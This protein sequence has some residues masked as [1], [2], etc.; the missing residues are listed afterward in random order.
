[1]IFEINRGAILVVLLVRRENLFNVSTVSTALSKLS[2]PAKL[3]EIQYHLQYQFIFEKYIFKETSLT[4]IK[5]QFDFIAR[6]ITY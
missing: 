4:K 3:I 2:L 1:M 6:I 5:H